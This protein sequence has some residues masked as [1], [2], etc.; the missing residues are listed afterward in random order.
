MASLFAATHPDRVSG[1]ILFSSWAR[2]TWAPDYPWANKQAHRKE[3]VDAMVDNWGD[4]SWAAGFAPSK[5]NDRRFMDVVRQAPALR[6]SAWG[7]A[8][9]AVPGG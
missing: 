8:Q 9:A 7:C 2:M 3:L 1:L 4:G 5:L 6:R